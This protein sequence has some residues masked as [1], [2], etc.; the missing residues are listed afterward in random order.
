MPRTPF[1]FWHICGKWPNRWS[2]L[3][4]MPPTGQV[5]GYGSVVGRSLTTLP[6]VLISCLV[7]YIFWAPYRAPGW[8]TI[9]Q[10]HPQ[11]AGCHPLFTDTWNQILLWQDKVLNWT[12]HRSA[13]YHHVI[14]LKDSHN[15]STGNR[16]FVTLHFSKSFSIKTTVQLPNLILSHSFI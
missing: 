11:E 1:Q 6:A 15:N 7:I 12:R 2:A 10:G 3:G 9:C 4:P 5:T 14:Y 13:V 8:Q 16:L